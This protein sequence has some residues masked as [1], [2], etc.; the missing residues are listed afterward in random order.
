MNFTCEKTYIHTS[1]SGAYANH[2]KIE[3]KGETSSYSKGCKKSLL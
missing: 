1:P 2:F 3:M